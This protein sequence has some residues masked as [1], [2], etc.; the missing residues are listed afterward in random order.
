[1]IASLSEDERPMNLLKAR[2]ARD[3]LR[4]LKFFSF[5]SFVLFDLGFTEETT[6]IS[7]LLA[8][9]LLCFVIFLDLLGLFS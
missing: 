9:G 1:L 5:F 2:F 7:S 8:F 6:G 3:L 4:S